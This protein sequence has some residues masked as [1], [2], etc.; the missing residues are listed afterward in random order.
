MRKVYILLIELLSFNHTEKVSS[1]NLRNLENQGS[2]TI[3]SI[4]YK[5]SFHKW[6]G[7][8]KINGYWPL[9]KQGH[10]VYFS[11]FF[12]WKNLGLLES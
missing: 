9:S 12:D 7:N 3:M 5:V 8:G 11:R 10:L 1:L 4:S 6:C 2:R